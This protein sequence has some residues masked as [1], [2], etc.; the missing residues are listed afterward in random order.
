MAEKHFIL[1]RHFDGTVDRESSEARSK[2]AQHQAVP[3]IEINNPEL[4]TRV[5]KPI[6]ANGNPSRAYIESIKAGKLQ[7]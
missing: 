3:V 7:K 6:V 1:A 2:A 5:D 4:I